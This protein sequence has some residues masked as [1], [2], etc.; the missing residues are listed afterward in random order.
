[1][2]L[3]G[4]HRYA[5]PV[6]GLAFCSFLSAILSVIGC[7]SEP[8]EDSGLDRVCDTQQA[9]CIEQVARAVACLREA[10][11]VEPP[12][13]KRITAAELGASDDRTDDDIEAVNRVYG[14]LSLFR[15]VPRGY[16]FERASRDFYATIPAFY[17]S[18]S[19]EI[20]IVSDAESPNAERAY[21]VL[22]HE[23]VHYQQD[24]E[25]NL[26]AYYGRYADGTDRSLGVQAAIEGEAI[27]YELIANTA[28]NGY[29]VDIVD[30]RSLWSEFQDRML[31]EAS[32]TPLPS[33]MASRLFPYAF[34]GQ[35]IFD[36]W[37][38][39]N[40]VGIEEA[41]FPPP[42]ST[43]QVLA[44]PRTDPP[45]PPW[46]HDAMMA[47][48]FAPVLPENY[49]FLGAN[50]QGVWLVR[51]M[52]E[53]FGRV[54]GALSQAIQAVNAD[55]LSLFHDETTD[56]P[57][58]VWRLRFDDA[59]SASTFVASFDDQRDV[60]T[61]VTDN[62]D[63][64]VVAGADALVTLDSEWRSREAIRAEQDMMASAMAAAHRGGCAHAPRPK[65]MLTASTKT[66]R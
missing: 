6:P 58:A 24:L 14:A 35:L 8:C 17:D 11:D 16:T 65:L 57:A 27:T 5:D 50:P 64:V 47:D 9:S 61:L 3:C 41:M 34:G 63:V 21:L 60:Y 53:R 4:T 49:A 39:G 12:P 23:M 13:V 45:V 59:N 22:V 2:L 10:P 48:H 7:G 25:F 51:A 28:V 1:M 37:R 36:Q 62:G 44:W 29:T 38:A 66:P 31:R 56:T 52:L 42:A 15:L 54:D 46:N 19:D 43:R 26:G 40:R 30:W 32:S 18:G 20:V 55:V 33:V